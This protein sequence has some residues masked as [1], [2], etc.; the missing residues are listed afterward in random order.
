M[1]LDRIIKMIKVKDLL[2]G[3]KIKYN[4]TEVYVVAL[5]TKKAL[6]DKKKSG[7]GMTIETQCL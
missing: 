6:L 1:S 7:F 5:D 2:I 4:N 3:N